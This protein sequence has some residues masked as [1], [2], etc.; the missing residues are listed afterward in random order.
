MPLLACVI[1]KESKP[2]ERLELAFRDAASASSLL[3]SISRADVT[4]DELST[5]AAF[6][7]RLSMA[8]T[9]QL[10]VSHLRTVSGA[11]MHF[12]A[13]IDAYQLFWLST[14]HTEIQTSPDGPVMHLD[15][16][17]PAGFADG[18]DV[19]QI[20]HA[21]DTDM[22]CLY[23]S[24]A[25]VTQWAASRLEAPVA[26]RVRFDWPRLRDRRFVP[27]LF[28]LAKAL[29]DGLDA[30]GILVTAPLALDALQDA[31]VSMLM[32]SIP[33]TL[34][35]ALRAKEAP[36]TAPRSVIRAIDF[37]HAHAHRPLSIVDVAAAAQ[38]SVRAL[39]LAFKRSR[40]STPMEYLRNLRLR[41]VRQDLLDPSKPTT[42]SA[43]AMGWGFFHMGMFA[44][45]YRAAYGETPSE[46]LQRR[47][48]GPLARTLPK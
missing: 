33:H 45:L 13:G 41:R 43:I 37:M 1:V 23:V 31:I 14:G 27:V 21:A 15:R 10:R 9:R 38:C 42:V 34:S 48:S 20:R 16:R 25:A 30:D 7:L 2:P 24:G 22:R 18:M 44:R 46:T 6:E 12:A 35:E 29:E 32:E 17:E 5:E 36:P 3:S 8:R 19:R 39:Q 47:P 40:H 28:E 26:S 4:V 11:A